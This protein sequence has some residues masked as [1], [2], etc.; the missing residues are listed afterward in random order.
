MFLDLAHATGNI[1]VFFFIKKSNK[2]LKFNPDCALDT[3]GN[4]SVTVFKHT[5]QKN[6]ET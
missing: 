1:S 3:M 6:V 4:D 5:E 2:V